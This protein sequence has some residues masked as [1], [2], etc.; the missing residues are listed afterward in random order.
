MHKKTSPDRRIQRTR[1]LLLN[2]LIELI[3]EKGYETITVQD[4][5]DRANVGRST[6]Y[7]HFQD[8]EDL[9]L[10]GFENFR[11]QFEEFLMAQSFTDESPWILSLSIF[12]HAQNQ[13]QLYKALAGKQGG[14]VTLAHIQKYLF[15]LMQT[16][17]RQQLW[18]SKVVFPADI[19]A[20]YVSSSII[21][22]LTWWLDNDSPYSA[23]QINV[24]FRQLVQ[25][26]VESFLGIT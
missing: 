15:A 14:N 12:Q 10:S 5:I 18:R 6:F 9:L 21:S 23:E 8:K 26:G 16:H 4:I 11:T 19:L 7:S 24:F 3:L 13:R 20:Q 22:L 1:Q 2:S 25:P 17:F